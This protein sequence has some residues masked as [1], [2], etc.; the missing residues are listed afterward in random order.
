MYVFRESQLTP[1]G[2]LSIPMWE[3]GM[4][5]FP[6]SGGSTNTNFIFPLLYKESDLTSMKK[7]IYDKAQRIQTSPSKNCYEILQKLQIS[8]NYYVLKK[9]VNKSNGVGF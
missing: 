3:T 5:S 9:L 7:K 2:C 8:I 4:S 1:S 6:V